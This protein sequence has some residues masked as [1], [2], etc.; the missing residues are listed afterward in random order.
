MNN[1]QLLE[2]P[3]EIISTLFLGCLK[4]DEIKYELEE[5]LFNQIIQWESFCSKL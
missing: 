5:K 1:Y 4:V 3:I 2:L